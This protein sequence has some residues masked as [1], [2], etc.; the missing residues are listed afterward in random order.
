MNERLRDRPPAGGVPGSEFAAR[1]AAAREAARAEGLDGLLVCAGPGAAPGH[2]A[3]ALYLANLRHGPPGPCAAAPHGPPPCRSGGDGAF[4]FLPVAGPEV[5]VAGRPPGPEAALP[6]GRIRL[7]P[8]TVET[9]AREIAAAGLGAGRI[10]LVGAEGLSPAG[11][12][13]LRE[14]LPG[15]ALFDAQP[16]LD[17][18]RTVKSP[19]EIAR[20]RAAARLGSRAVEAMMAAAAP[21]TSH[22]ALVAAGQE[23]LAA[24]GATLREGV[25]ASGRGGL[26]PRHLAAAFPSWGARDAMLRTGDWLRLGLSGTLEGYGFAIA[27]SRPVGAAGAGQVALFEAA[28]AVVEAAIAAIRPG[29][30]AQDVAEAALAQERALGQGGAG[31]AP[32][33]GHGIGLGADAPRLAPGCALRIGAG[34]V[35]RVGRT[36]RRDGLVATFGETVLVTPTGCERLTDAPARRW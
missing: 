8:G 27:R 31:G 10:G 7:A 2:A 29:V 25:L 3:D 5:L 35:L 26:R 33:I 15:L 14:R 16:L 32:A 30:R 23:M 11:E 24:A 21:G 28:I 19:A 36:I 1:R 20:L 17:R 6:A 18:L 4:L 12:A 13:E 34:M 22:A 9:T